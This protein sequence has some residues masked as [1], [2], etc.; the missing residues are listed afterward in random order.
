M[1]P[2][3]G[4]LSRRIYAIFLIVAVV[5]TA[6]AGAFGVYASLHALRNETINNLE[7]EVS[8]RAEGVARFLAQ[9]ASEL[10]YL[11][12]S[13]T[14]NGFRQAL[15]READ[16]LENW[17]LAIE[18]EYSNLARFY[19]HIY[20]IRFLSGDGFEQIRVDRVDD[21]VSVVAASQL[22]YKGDRYYF[23]DAL[24]TPSGSVYVSPLDLNVEFGLIEEPERPVI[25]MAVPLEADSERGKG[26]L[27]VNLH[28]DILLNQIQQMA[29][30]REGYALLFDRAGYYLS[31]RDGSLV[32]DSGF[33]MQPV[34]RLDELFG[35][36]VVGQLLHGDGVLEKGGWIVAGRAV[37]FEEQGESLG[38][39][40]IAIAFPERA[41]LT[42]VFSLYGL[43]AVLLSALM[44]TAA[45]GYFVSRRFIGPID[46]LAKETEAITRGDFKRRVEIPGDDEIAALGRR[47]N[48]MTARLD[49]MY[50]SLATRRDELER[51]VRA[52][53]VELER[54][55]H[56]LARLFERLSDGVV[57]VAP[58][59]RIL[60]CNPQARALLAV[61]ESMESNESI[62]AWG[63]W[64][65]LIRD[66][67]GE[68]E[69]RA[70]VS[71][72]S[73]TVS[74]SVSHHED[75]YILVAR[76]VTL[77]RRIEADRR[78]LDR[79]MFQMEKVITLGELAMGLAHEVGNPL[80]GMK[81]VAQAMQ[82]EE[83]L[84]V[85]VGEA[86]R[87]LE[88]EIDRLADFLKGFHGFAA[89]R[90]LAIQPCAFSEVVDDVFFWT[91]KEARSQ[92]VELSVDIG[93]D[94]PLLRADPAALK[95]VL[96]NLVLNALHAT[97]AGG[98]VRVAAVGAGDRVVIQVEDDGCGIAQDV[99]GRV[100][101]SF[102]TTR[103]E[104]SGLG[105]AVVRKI[106]QQHGGDIEVSSEL[107]VG[108]CF[109]LSWPCVREEHDRG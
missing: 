37:S 55:R 49:T 38:R 76:D 2:L 56:F 71:H 62:L 34:M 66:I 67:G 12:V 101:D 93:P 14:L 28:A 39:W 61:N 83:D 85:Q 63:P 47:F 92:G 31:R 89:P 77:E 40:L 13:P 19:P 3:F 35:D 6:I 48:D 104:G 22:Q 106:V 18:N 86:L 107:G 42:Q 27:I 24:A 52:R 79:Q 23:S 4:S 7:Q 82:Y 29:G 65:Q 20:Q 43:Y 57:Q 73:S 8:I 16:T 98:Q 41:L 60:L 21:K 64:P 30:V 53:T 45:G 109:A 58:D 44:V 33:A 102:F 70:D 36:G 94:L 88:R 81:A 97:Q 91:H 96:L 100:F 50:S 105:L 32:D 11:S 75:G 80:A 78:D 108:T 99:L 9:L 51:E 68:R 95:Q 87:R 103:A 15:H 69:I 26:L 25:R 10:R 59:G 74:V 17:R 5:P 46:Q 54:E 72:D 90:A 84:P 1:R